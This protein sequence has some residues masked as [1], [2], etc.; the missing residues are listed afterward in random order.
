MRHAFRRVIVERLVSPGWG[1]GTSD[2]LGVASSASKDFT[3]GQQEEPLRVRLE[4]QQQRWWCLI[5]PDF[6]RVLPIGPECAI[7]GK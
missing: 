6:A 4:S 5:C 7:H 3:P 1:L 2:L